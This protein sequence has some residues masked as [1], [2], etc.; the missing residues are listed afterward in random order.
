MDIVVYGMW[1]C[2]AVYLNLRAYK[3]KSNT[4]NTSRNIQIK[5]GKTLLHS[6]KTELGFEQKHG[7]YSGHCYGNSLISAP[8]KGEQGEKLLSNLPLLS[9]EV[10]K[11]RKEKEHITI[12][13]ALDLLQ[14]T[15]QRKPSDDK[16]GEIYLEFAHTCVPARAAPSMRWQTS[17]AQPQGTGVVHTELKPPLR[18]LPD[19]SCLQ[20]AT[21]SIESG[22]QAEKT[23]A[24]S[25]PCPGEMLDVETIPVDG[26]ENSQ[27]CKSE[28]SGLRTLKFTCHNWMA[29]VRVFLVVLSS[30]RDIRPVLLGRQLPSV[31]TTPLQLRLI[32]SQRSYQYQRVSTF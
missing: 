32:S 31:L 21:E 30:H 24:C 1:F 16:T 3:T 13:L 8:R 20:T 4:D 2:V 29:R 19:G 26:E 28:M 25:G 10:K 27:R 18:C 12:G 7:R 6:L 23:S 14:W 5:Q 9:P 17:A 22:L 11:K 15:K